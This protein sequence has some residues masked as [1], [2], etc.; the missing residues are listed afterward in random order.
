LTNSPEKVAALERYGI[1]VAERVPHVFPSSG[2]NERYLRTKAI[3]SGHLLQR[4]WLW[5]VPRGATGS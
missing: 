5:V 4:A 1:R 2:H 3:R